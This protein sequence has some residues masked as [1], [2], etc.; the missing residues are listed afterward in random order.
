MFLERVGCNCVGVLI[1]III[2]L[3]NIYFEINKFNFKLMLFDELNKFVVFFKEDVE[4][5]IEI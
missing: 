4:R 2:D 3:K 5:K 1:I